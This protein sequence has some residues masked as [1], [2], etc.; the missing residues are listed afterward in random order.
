M[1]Q[2]RNNARGK[3]IN[4]IVYQL[5]N[6][7]SLLSLFLLKEKKCHVV[8]LRSQLEAKRLLW[9]YF[10]L[11]CNVLLFSK[12]CVRPLWIITEGWSVEKVD[13][14]QTCLFVPITSSSLCPGSAGM[15]SSYASQHSQLGQDLRSA[16]SPDRHI[17]P[18]YEDRTF[19]GPLYRSPSHNQQ[20]ALY[21]SSSGWHHSICWMNSDH[22]VSF[23]GCHYLQAHTNYRFITLNFIS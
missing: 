2:R 1:W 5:I 23:M 19:Q 4:L 14:L 11:F 22:K 10:P 13:L 7:S 15:R 6:V 17:A 3:R 20:G 16:I 8:F 12:F 9:L 21:R 18:I